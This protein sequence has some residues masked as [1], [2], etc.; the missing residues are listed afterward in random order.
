MTLYEIDNAILECVDEETG[1]IIDFE[2]L[3][4]LCIERENKIKNVAQWYKDTIADV[5]KF[6]AERDHCRGRS[7]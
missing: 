5:E 6:K 4:A 3:D 1:E 2:K 7:L